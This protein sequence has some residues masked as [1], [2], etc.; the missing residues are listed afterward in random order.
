MWKTLI[1]LFLISSFHQQTFAQ[2]QVEHNKF[3]E[4]PPE[5]VFAHLLDIK[6]FPDWISG[7][8][9]FRYK[10]GI[11]GT[12]GS[13]AYQVVQQQGIRL[14]F[15]Q[16]LLKVKQGEKV[17]IFMESE[18]MDIVIQYKFSEHKNGTMVHMVHDITPKSF[19]FRTMQ[20]MIR[21]SYLRNSESNFMA[22]KAIV[23]KK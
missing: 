11:P 22:F 2:F 21:R 13:K 14:E 15:I 4:A 17:K 7:F 5:V 9:S 10:S 12:E 19:L 18:Q 1:F 8:V 20:P 23:E 6:Y 3:I 16:T